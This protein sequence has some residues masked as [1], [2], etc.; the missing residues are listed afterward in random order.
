MYTTMFWSLWLFAVLGVLGDWWRSGRARDVVTYAN[1]RGCVVGL[2][3]NPG[4]V[5]IFRN[6]DQAHDPRSISVPLGFAQ[7]TQSLRSKEILDRYIILTHQVFLPRAYSGPPDGNIVPTFVAGWK[8]PGVRAQGGTFSGV[9]YEQ[10]IVSYWLVI[11][12]LSLV[13]A[14][15][16][17]R[18]ARRARRKRYMLRECRCLKCDYDL[19][20]SSERCPE[21]G[22]PIPASQKG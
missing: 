3:T 13:P 11:C 17:L 19:R 22:T 14:N 2:A 18:S 4:E 1:S 10:L 16:L 9:D 7:Y 12:V 15:H 5:I 6:T 21:C 20:G 8:V